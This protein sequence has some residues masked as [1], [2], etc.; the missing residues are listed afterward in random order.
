MPFITP[1][2]Q[3]TVGAGSDRVIYSRE[4]ES[5]CGLGD[6]CVIPPGTTLIMDRSIN[7]GALVVRGKLLWTDDKSPENAFL[8]AGYV[9]VEGQGI[10]EM[11]LE[12]KSGWIYIKE[13]GAVHDMLRSRAFGG[14]G[15]TNAD[16]PVVDIQGRAMVRTWSLLSKPLMAGDNKMHLLHN[17]TYMKW[18]VGDRLG[19]A[20][21]EKHS[22][23]FGE[24]MRIVAIDPSTG[25][26]TLSSPVSNSFMASFEPPHVKGQGAMLMSAEVVNLDRN[27]ST[28]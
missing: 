22:T 1:T 11:K 2:K 14:V 18:Q 24:A 19:I 13:N 6:I 12:W 5:Q 4:L 20:P 23:G 25:T 26:I 15:R 21:T 10:W 17:P 9:A 16:N 8:C 28:V 27:V 3:V 7:L